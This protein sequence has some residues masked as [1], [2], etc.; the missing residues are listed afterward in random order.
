MT[1]EM[2]TSI[3]VVFMAFDVLYTGG[4]DD[5]GNSRSQ[6]RRKRAGWNWSSGSSR[7][8]G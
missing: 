7:E 2:R 3:P 1:A 5:H 8:P 4:V 6:E